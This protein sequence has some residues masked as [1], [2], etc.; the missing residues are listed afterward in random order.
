LNYIDSDFWDKQYL[1][2]IDY[3]V[4][5]TVELSEILSAA[6]IKQKSR[7]LD[8]GCGTG[9]LTRE[10]F[11]RGMGVV[12]ADISQ[13]ALKIA[14]SA[15]TCP[16]PYVNPKQVDGKFDAIICKHVVAFLDLVHVRNY[17]YN[18]LGDE[19]ILIIITPIETSAI[20]EYKPQICI[21]EAVLLEN[22]KEAFD[23]LGT[24]VKHNYTTYILKVK[25]P[26]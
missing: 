8:Y 6:K 24:I 9:L 5:P 11:H 14:R 12:G 20:Y 23:L 19:G 13:S 25:A 15:T 2:G 21:Q 16:I 3:L 22:M 10:L 1:Q 26:A 18:L 4:L 17:F 7:I